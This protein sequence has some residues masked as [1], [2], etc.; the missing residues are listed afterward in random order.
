MRS[1]FLIIY[2]A[3]IIVAGRGILD[4]MGPKTVNGLSEALFGDYIAFWDYYQD[5]L[6]PDFAGNPVWLAIGGLAAILLLRLAPRLIRGLTIGV[7]AFFIADISATIVGIENAKMP[8]F[9]FLLYAM[10]ASGTLLL[11]RALGEPH[12]WLFVIRTRM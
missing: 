10:I 1:P 5:Q 3:M 12:F 9:D 11:L 7:L 6:T 8:S 4:W 2:F